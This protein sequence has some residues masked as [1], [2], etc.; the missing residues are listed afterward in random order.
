MTTSALKTPPFGRGR[1]FEVGR[2]RRSLSDRQFPRVP[3]AARPA[4]FAA[5]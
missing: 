4:G 1:G 2:C 5:I 3:P